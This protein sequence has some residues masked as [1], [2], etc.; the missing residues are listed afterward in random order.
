M[1]KDAHENLLKEANYFLN[2]LKIK[3]SDDVIDRYIKAHKYVFR[4]PEIEILHVDLKTI[5]QKK[6]D[7]EAIEFALRF[8]NKDNLLTKKIH[9]LIYIL[10]SKQKYNDLFLNY[11]KNF[12]KGFSLLIFYTLR[13][14]YLLSKGKYL[15]WRYDLV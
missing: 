4:S 10:E 12:L 2:I 14:I 8:S 3:H 5:I 15:I 6:L 9:M 13:S 7:L 11:E 1:I